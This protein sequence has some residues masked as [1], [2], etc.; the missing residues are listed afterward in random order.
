MYPI[1]FLYCQH[2]ESSLKVIMQ[3]CEALLSRPMSQ[4]RT[5]NLQGLWAR[6]RPVPLDAFGDSNSDDPEVITSCIG[7][8]SKLD[9]E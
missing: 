7:Q 5:Q 9:P 1:L 6:C 8:F 2:L 4:P 3:D